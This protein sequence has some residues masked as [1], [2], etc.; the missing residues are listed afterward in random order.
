[1]FVCQPVGKWVRVAVA[2]SEGK[3]KKLTSTH[4]VLI[5]ACVTVASLTHT[6]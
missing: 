5:T 4:P 2:A 1:M 6:A 3:K